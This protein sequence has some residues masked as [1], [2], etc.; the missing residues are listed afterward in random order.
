M[1]YDSKYLVRLTP[2]ERE[3]LQGVVRRGKVAGAKRTR[4]RRVR[5]RRTCRSPK[6][7]KC[8]REP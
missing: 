2:E 1:N 7:S 6:P 5:E 8:R 3:E 4:A